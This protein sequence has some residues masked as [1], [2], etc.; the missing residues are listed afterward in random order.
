[1]WSVQ[2]FKHVGLDRRILWG[3]AIFLFSFLLLIMALEDRL[4]YFPLK[5]PDGFWDIDRLPSNPA[6]VVPRIEEC[7]F[8]APDGVKLHGWF[9]VPHRN[10]GGDLVPEAAEMVLL[11]FHGNAGNISHRYG[12]IRAVMPLRVNVFIIDYRGYGKSEGRPSEAG[13]YLDARAAWDYLIEHRGISADRI[14]IFGKSLGSAPAIDL[15]A[16][17]SPAG[18]IV[19]SGFT[20][21]A[22]V[23]AT[24][25]PFF[26]RFLLRTK[27]ESQR[28]IPDVRCPKLFVHSPADEIIPYRLGRRLFEAASEPKQFYEVTG[29]SHND[30]FEVGGRKYLETLQRFIQAA[31]EKQGLSATSHP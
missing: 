10:S 2:V 12:M 8:T 7:W 27:M 13:L 18:L 6:E 16:Q 24:I 15:A 17:T 21:V 31:R 11:W 22:D 28:K 23:A 20:S 3:A 30:T 14:I 19:Q 25:L 4:I 9:C 5:Y 1:M 26:P 29:A